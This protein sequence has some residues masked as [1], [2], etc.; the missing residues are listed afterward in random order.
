MTFG[1]E[2]LYPNLVEKASALCF[3]LVK[4]H[5]FVDGNKRV[6][7]AVMETFLVLNGHEVDALSTEQEEVILR[8]AAGELNRDDFTEWMRGHIQIRQ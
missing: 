8:L 2:A 7:H 1:G 6:G 3:S 5:P 4:N